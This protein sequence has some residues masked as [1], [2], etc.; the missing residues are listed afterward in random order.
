MDSTWYTAESFTDSRLPLPSSPEWDF[1]H[2]VGSSLIHH[3]EMWNCSERYGEYGG[4]PGI[5]GSRD[6]VI[7]FFWVCPTK[8]DPDWSMMD[9]DTSQTLY[10][11][12]GSRTSNPPGAVNWDSG[13]NILD[14]F[15]MHDVDDT[16]GYNLG[17][18]EN[19][20]QI[21]NFTYANFPITLWPL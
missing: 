10:G 11:G 12:H 15:V 21:N 16:Y 17:N 3:L 13:Q 1:K 5:V 20:V 18:Y 14:N 2:D 6:W 4:L 7:K 19:Y 8:S 9:L